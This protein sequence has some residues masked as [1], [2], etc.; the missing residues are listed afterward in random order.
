MTYSGPLFIIYASPTDKRL[1]AC[2]LRRLDTLSSVQL[3]PSATA[4][5]CASLTDAGGLDSFDEGVADAGAE[6]WSW[7]WSDGDA[8][9]HQCTED[10]LAF[11]NFC[12]P[13][14][15]R[16][17]LTVHPSYAPSGVVIRGGTDT[18]P[19]AA[20]VGASFRSNGAPAVTFTGS[21]VRV[22]VC[23]RMHVELCFS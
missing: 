5:F 22:K 8:I 3:T 18:L 20:A 13:P 14:R 4:Q 21:P 10:A 6:T 2:R 9:L 15:D 17:P 12:H 19:S 23:E 11:L 1:L 16:A 7:N